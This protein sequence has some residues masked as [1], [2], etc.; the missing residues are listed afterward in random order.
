VNTISWCL[1]VSLLLVI[2]ASVF[3][4]WSRR[5]VCQMFCAYLR[6][7]ADSNECDVKE[8]DANSA[9]G[10]HP[11]KRSIEQL[12]A[13]FKSMGVWGYVRALRGAADTAEEVLLQG[14]PIPMD[15]AKSRG[16]Q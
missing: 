10:V 3:R 15:N 16:D 14:K 12:E 6:A 11:S 5:R 9:L 7:M 13:G 8:L 1:L 2:G 4:E